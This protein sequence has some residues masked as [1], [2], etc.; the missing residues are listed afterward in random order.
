MLRQLRNLRFWLLALPLAW[1]AMVAL[2][3]SGLPEPGA[4]TPDELAVKVAEALR[5]HDAHKLTPLISV[6]G[7][8]IA[9]ATVDHY[10][11]VRVDRSRFVG[12]AVVV[13][14]VHADG[15]PDNTRM[16]AAEHD[17]RWLVTPLATP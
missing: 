12:D 14:F 4:A 17:G 1:L 16:P 15:T 8:P 10:S 5:E 7:E 11:G 13:E 2:Q 6:G 3:I 9:K